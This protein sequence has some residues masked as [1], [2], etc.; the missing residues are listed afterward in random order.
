[1][2]VAL[3]EV[4]FILGRYLPAGFLVAFL[5]A[6]PLALLSRRR[7][8]KVGAVAA[9]AALILILIFG[10]PSGL[11]IASPHAI[12]GAFM[13]ALL[14]VNRGIPSCA[15]VSI[16]TRVILYP[17]GFLLFA[18]VVI[19][20]GRGGYLRQDHPSSTGDFGQLP[21]S[22]RD[23]PVYCWSPGPLRCFPA[24]VVHRSRNQSGRDRAAL[25][26]T[27][28]AALPE[29]RHDSG[30]R[31]GLLTNET[32]GSRNLALQANHY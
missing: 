13:G 1:M 18:Y 12:C 16:G 10:G 6:V 11:F 23:I 25:Y 30:H 5:A 21:G 17:V 22:G 28:P 15:L 4:L 8:L 19:G 32:P 3:S 20:R 26:P 7:G 24:P 27:G 14:R 29:Y 2:V 31:P 9:T